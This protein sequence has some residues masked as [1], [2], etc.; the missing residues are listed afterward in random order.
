M[1]HT[2]ITAECFSLTT[3]IQKGVAAISG[4]VKDFGGARQELNAIKHDLV[5]LEDLVKRIVN[6]YKKLE[7]VQDSE[8]P[9]AIRTLVIHSLKHSI[10]IVHDFESLLDKDGS[11]KV[12]IPTWWSSNGRDIAEK[13]KVAL[14]EQHTKLRLG[15]E[16]IRV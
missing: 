4:F 12:S 5:A 6:G 1:D 2:S 11:S 16:Y 15:N 10:S 3:A 13:F 9:E 7:L 14:D 8:L